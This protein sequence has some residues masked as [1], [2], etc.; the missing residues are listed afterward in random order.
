MLQLIHPRWPFPWAIR[1]YR[2]LY[3]A[4]DKFT[5]WPKAT[6]VV[7]INKQ[8]VIKFIKSIAYRFRVPN[9][10]IANNGSQL[11]SSAFHG[12][13][14]DLRIKI[15]YASVAHLE[16]MARSGLMSI[17][18]HCGLTRHHPVGPLGRHLS[19]W[20]LGLRPSSP[21]QSPCAPYVSRHTMKPCKTS[22]GVK[23][24]T[25]STSKDGNQLLR[26]HGTAR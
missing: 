5:K 1:G 25:S 9:K 21:Q 6:P 24:S 14:E 15:C 26:M 12:Y 16:S 22:S 18:A 19:S 3:F 17:R 7:K 20:C 13:C 10:I 2:Y 11:S 4:I 23:I 8:Y